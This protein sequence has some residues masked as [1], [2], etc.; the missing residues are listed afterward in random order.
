MK[1]L[2]NDEISDELVFKWQ[3]ICFIHVHIAYSGFVFWI[4]TYTHG[5]PS[6]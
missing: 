5:V 1:F 2:M 3:P 4:F 6:S